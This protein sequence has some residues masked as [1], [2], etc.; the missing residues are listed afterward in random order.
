[1]TALPGWCGQGSS[2]CEQANPV[3]AGTPWFC[4]GQS[5]GFMSCFLKSHGHNS[6]LRALGLAAC[7]LK[8]APCCLWVP[9]SFPSTVVNCDS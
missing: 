8:Y 1:M 5:P 3:T 9:V 2:R 6:E 7:L 4:H